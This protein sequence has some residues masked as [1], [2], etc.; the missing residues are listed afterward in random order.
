MVF[1]SLLQLI[2]SILSIDMLLMYTDFT[3]I[4][5]S[6]F[7]C[8]FDAWA[9]NVGECEYVRVNKYVTKHIY[10]QVKFCILDNIHFDAIFK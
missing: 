10:E 6:Q 8:N 9:I 5:Y 2:Q 7:S 1:T 3:P 4:K